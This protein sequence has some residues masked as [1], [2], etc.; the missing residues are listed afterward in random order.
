MVGVYKMAASD[1]LDSLSNQI[2]EELPSLM[3]ESLPAVDPV[4]TSVVRTSQQVVRD[5]IGRGW[6]VMH[7]FRT[8]L[9]G[10]YEPMATT[11]GTP[12]TNTNQSISYN[13]TLGFPD[14][15]KTPHMGNIIREITL[16]AHRGNFGV[17]LFLLKAES[18]QSV[19]FNDLVD[20]LKGLAELRAQME[21]LS[22][23][24]PS[25][26]Y[27]ALLESSGATAVETTKIR[28]SVSSTRIRWFKEG[29][30][31][32]IYDDAS[33]T[34]LINQTTAGAIVVL[35]DAV[36][37]LNGTIT[38]A[39]PSGVDLNTGGGGS[40]SV[41]AGSAVGAAD[42][43]IFPRNAID[44]STIYR[45]GHYG[46][47]D[48]IKSSGTLFGDAV[49]WNKTSGTTT[50]AFDLATYP[51]FKSLVTA[52][53]SSTPLTELILT[54]KLGAFLDAYDGSVDTIIT[55]R[56]V[57]QKYLEQAY[58][59]A[60][61]GSR[62][63]FDRTG[64][65]TDLVGGW[66]KASYEYEGQTYELKMSPYCQTGTLYGIKM[67]DGNIKRFVPPGAQGVG[68]IGSPGTGMGMDG[69]IEF[70]APMGGSGSIF[71]LI[72]D[73]STGGAT[74][75]VEAPF[76]QYSQVAP[77]DVRGLKLSNLTESIG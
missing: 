37:R 62:M 14:A 61:N 72:S 24:M 31:V 75:Q 22:F 27:I 30:M 66:T 42:Q 68:G 54:Q 11:G 49:V 29:M 17:P 9:S 6:K 50:A 52:Y 46:L 51:Q 73:T 43:Y 48:W 18:L 57:V 32:D 3:L 20:D 59:G 19:A 15:K 56:G 26:K 38:L 76:Q 55:T 74:N 65:A 60:S 21:A 7:R 25:A 1:I 70:I 53:G 41:L 2:R 40:T 8:S 33:G 39:N 71:R 77:V 45:I 64:K 28:V 58:L 10:M 13:T 16:N 69:E 63:N 47:D 44:G 23:Y 67:G 4:Y 12:Y 36:D 34:T 5:E 35:V